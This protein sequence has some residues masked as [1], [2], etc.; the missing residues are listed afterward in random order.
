M[1]I[2]PH[3]S[4]RRGFSLVLSLTIMAMMVMVVIVLAA[5]LSVESKLAKAAQ[6]RTQSRL[7]ALVSLRLAIGHLQQEAGPDRRMT[8]RADI[9]ANGLY[10]PSNPDSCPSSSNPASWTWATLPNPLW[11]GVW[12]SDR[13][14]QPPAWLVSGRH[15]KAANS[16]TINLFGQTD[17]TPEQ[18]VPWQPDY[19]P[20]PQNSPAIMIP[21]VGPASATTY[22][23]ATPTT[24][25]RPEGRISLPKISLPDANVAGS[26]CYWIGDEGVKARI[27]MQDARISPPTTVA[28]TEKALLQM[29]GLRG[30]ARPGIEALSAFSK[31]PASG[32]DPRVLFL[33]QL[34]SLDS[35]I[36]PETNPPT[37]T[38]S[39]WAD[40]TMYS[41]G[42]LADC[43]F[44][45]L[46]VDLSLAFEKSDTDFYNSEFV[47]G[48]P[49]DI[50]GATLPVLGATYVFNET[51]SPSPGP[52]GS[53]GRS[54]FWDARVTNRA[55]YK[56]GDATGGYQTAPLYRVYYGNNASKPITGPTWESLRSYYNLYKEV[57]WSG[58]TPNLTARAAYPNTVAFSNAGYGGTAYYS[59][60]FNRM[61]DGSTDF[62]ASD[63]VAG[64][65]A[66]RLTKVGVF[67]YVARQM[68]VLGLANNG[69]FV[70]LVFSP[71]TVLHNPYNVPLTL[72][73]VANEDA[74]MRLS[75]RYWSDWSFNFS[76]T[77]NTNTTTYWS[78]D[79]NTMT[80]SNSSTSN[81]SEE[82]R[83]YI[84]SNTV[85]QP[86][87]F[88]VFTSQ[89]KVPVP[90]TATAMMT[91]GFNY[92][93]G[94][95]IPCLDS[96]KA[97]PLRLSPTE[98][99]QIGL[100][101]YGT[102]ENGFRT[103][104]VY[105]RH[106][107][108]SWPGDVIKDAS[109]GEYYNKC[110]EI[111][112]LTSNA[113]HPWIVG[114]VPMKTISGGNL[115]AVGTP[116]LPL[117]VVDFS[118]RW[119]IDEFGATSKNGSFPLFIHSNPMATQ[120]RP[121]ATGYSPNNAVVIGGPTNAVAGNWGAPPSS[122]SNNFFSTTSTSFKLRIWN[123]ASS[124]GTVMATSGPNDELAFGGTTNGPTG[125]TK[126]VYT[127]VP[128]S[129]PISIAQF[130]HANFGI[131]DQE[132]LFSIGNSFAPSF[133]P[134]NGFGATT[135][136]GPSITWVDRTH[137]ANCALFDRYFFSG[138]A[139]EI[140][141]GTVK[142]PQSQ[143]ISDFVSYGTPMLNPRISLFSRRD[144]ATTLK[145]VSNHR[146]IAGSVLNEGAFNINSTSV[147]AWA[148]MLSNAKRNAMGRATEEAPSSKSNTRFPRA[149]QL[150]DLT[151]NYKSPFSSKDAWTG[152]ATLD[153]N[154]ILILARN[155]VDE[156]RWRARD[157]HRIEENMWGQGSPIDGHQLPVFRGKQ[158][159]VPFRCLSE[160]VNR[161]HC[162]AD[163]N[164][165]ITS[166][167]GCLQS[168]IMRADS[169]GAELSNRST[170][171]ATTYDA[172]SFT[173]IG[174]S[175]Y[176]AGK[177][178]VPFSGDAHLDNLQ[179]QDPRYPKS[180]RGHML[181]ASPASLLQSDILEAIGPAL[182]GRSDTFI[183]RAYGEVT[184][185]PGSISTKAGTWVEAVVQRTPEFI[186]ASQP[187]ETEVHDPLDVAKN[188]STDPAK[189]LKSVNCALGR[190]FE[191][192]SVRFLSAKDL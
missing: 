22:E 142:R 24:A 154:Q 15:D 41:K 106:L 147:Q 110:S 64:I 82:F 21:L 170:S 125:Q 176:R 113:M 54:G 181:M 71:V 42:V 31:M 104:P 191:I 36:Y 159:V 157:L 177:G 13:P 115:Q 105:I 109:I 59:H 93:G 33:S 128:L 55:S 76:R 57:T 3:P 165:V 11:T 4:S 70:N 130:T 79:M 168:A 8:A 149:M 180:P 73:S 53:T 10:P 133:S 16:Q 89:N 32:I 2:A 28:S 166:Y 58:T 101:N 127:E 99:L 30:A 119:P 103:S 67:P 167:A 155:I 92:Q 97:S 51:G 150:G 184:E 9:T 69:G 178:G 43:R 38:P 19:N 135:A 80:R 138:A 137:I 164:R 35:S 129:A 100:S 169:D 47:T 156:I 37:L 1:S 185:M 122:P 175:D 96:D 120:T 25:G 188:N 72:K 162:A 143:V 40:T 52:N 17:Y 44:G 34:S 111:T 39:I 88:R 171:P 158:T 20:T 183:I 163:T 116:S 189:K 123:P 81:T 86:G 26:Y 60:K 46:Q 48:T 23:L 126:A 134:I 63:T 27:N 187:P 117:A 12:R 50:D 186:D 18:W 61:D 132:P 94:F 95:L 68:M 161:F 84:P 152:L 151:Y 107:L 179:I 112:E 121:E 190:R 56:P 85:I 90:I 140:H 74:A 131:T 141:G 49:K 6:Y 145:R 5:F 14:T 66:M 160:F 29:E 62:W 91:N 124:W 139:P 173:G 98:T 148:I 102:P 144:S 136:Y 174:T 78:V 108:S 182:A 153:D 118:V 172:S 192:L 114:S 7:Q 83:C 146:Q 77:T 65:D 87:E 45:G 75:Y